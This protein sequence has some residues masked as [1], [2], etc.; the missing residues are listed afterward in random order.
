MQEQNLSIQS[1]QLSQEIITAQFR[2]ELAVHKYQEALDALSSFEV[3]EDTLTQAQEKVKNARKFSKTIEE[4][5]SKG[6]APALQECKWW[7]NAFNSLHSPLTTVISDVEKKIN[8]VAK[9]VAEENQRKERERLRIE[10]IK[11]SIE[12]FVFEQT[13][14]I[15]SATTD[16]ELVAIEKLIGSHKANKSRYEELLPSLVE[17]CEELTPLIKKQKEHIRELVEIERKKNE[18]LQKGDDREAME[19]EEKKESVQSSIE[20]TKIIIQETAIESALS[21]T[22]V[23]EVKEVLVTPKPRRT[24]WEME[25]VDEKKAF[26]SGMLVCEINKEKAKAQLLEVVKQTLSKDQEE[27]TINGIRYYQ[28]KIY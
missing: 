14:N 15:A 28:N 24:K 10:G 17:K 16:V 8:D 6:K 22:D 27:M 25:I 18:A 2:K 12:E 5:K 7:D 23:I 3:T 1:P 26:N 20:E 13:R 19:L 4:I 9:K 21:S 11:K